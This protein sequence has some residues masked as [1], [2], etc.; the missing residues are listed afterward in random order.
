VFMSGEEGVR[1]LF[2]RNAKGADISVIEGVMG[3]YDGASFDSGY[4]SSNH[5]A[6]ITQTP[7]ILV[8]DV[9]GMGRSLSAV[10]L[11]FAS[12]EQNRLAGIILNNCPGK[13][14]DQYKNLIEDGCGLHVYGHLPR[15]KEAVIASRHL[16][17]ITADEIA[18]IDKKLAALGEAA[19]Q[20]IDLSGILALGRTAPKLCC[21]NLWEGLKKAEGVRIGVAKDS[22]FSFLYQDNIDLL[23]ELGATII[24]FS[25]IADPVMPEVDGLILSGGYPEEY[26]R[27]L[28][29]NVGMQQSIR[30][31]VTGGMPTLAECGGFMYLLESITC[32]DSQS[33]KMAGVIPGNAF[34]TQKLERFGYVSLTAKHDGLLCKKGECIMGHEFHYSDSSNNGDGFTAHK[35]DRQWDCLHSSRTLF[36]GYPHIHFGADTGRAISF[37]DA[38]IKYKGDRK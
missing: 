18:G 5:V 2:A 38:C 11:G 6:A 4:A 3:M 27:L 33:C 22:A 36:A 1:F 8:V 23:E 12:F 19:A 21:K 28:Q 34:M 24:C 35:K 9:K 32:A 15:L 20:Y 7:Q 10:V 31:A 17:L 13:L 14:Y 30:K 25:P 37:I 26:A 29:D 16:G